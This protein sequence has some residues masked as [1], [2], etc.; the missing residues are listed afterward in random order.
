MFEIFAFR[1]CISM[2]EK[3]IVADRMC[4]TCADFKNRQAIAS[5]K[6]ELRIAISRKPRKKTG[7]HEGE[8]K[9]ECRK[10]GFIFCSRF[11]GAGSSFRSS[12]RNKMYCSSRYLNH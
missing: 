8:G 3:P 7:F 2:A 10:Q 12:F 1:S 5:V 4:S 9:R 11:D 6:R